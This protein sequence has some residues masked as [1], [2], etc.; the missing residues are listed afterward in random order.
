MWGTP[1]VDAYASLRD[2]RSARMVSMAVPNIYIATK[3]VKLSIAHGSIRFRSC[4][5]RCDFTIDSINHVRFTLG[6]ILFFFTCVSSEK[7][8]FPSTDFDN[9]ITSC[10]YSL[11]YD[12]WWCPITSNFDKDKSY[13]VCPNT[14]N[15]FGGNDP[16][17]ECYFPSIIKEKPQWE[18]QTSK[19]LL[20][21]CPTTE[22]F[23]MDKKWTHCIPRQ[24][25][26]LIHTIL[27][28]VG[29]AVSLIIIVMCIKECK[30]KSKKSKL[31]HEE[32]ISESTAPLPPTA[33]EIVSPDLRPPSY[34][35]LFPFT[36]QCPV[37]NQ[38]AII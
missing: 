10:K 27:I 9:Y 36:E 17:K 23:D 33:P 32:T 14:T 29:S 8:V 6:L 26:P 12:H 31:K 19:E 25:F 5:E 4:M 20:G 34:E 16:G 11:R 38:E 3:H 22:N 28:C 7:C 1:I 21:W 35:K 15:T 18:C 37:D 2:D 30:F 24:T 13:I